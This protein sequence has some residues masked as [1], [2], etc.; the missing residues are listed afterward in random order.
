MRVNPNVNDS[1]MK[2]R[3]GGPVSA[4][5]AVFPLAFSPDGTSVEGEATKR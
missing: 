1:P 3:G 5:G 4:G 2:N